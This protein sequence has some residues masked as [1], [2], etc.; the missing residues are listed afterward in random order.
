MGQ[1][2]YRPPFVF[3]AQPLYPPPM[4]FNSDQ[5]TILGAIDGV[6]RLFRIAVPLHRAQIYR[7]GVAQT[8]NFDCSFYGTMLKFVQASTPVKGD[9]VT[10]IG[11]VL[12]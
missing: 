9:R 8:L 11:F 4:Q 5:G 6:N 2:P 3:G 10:I 12:G 1:Q 7:N